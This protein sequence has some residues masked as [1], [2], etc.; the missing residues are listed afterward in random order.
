MDLDIENLAEVDALLAI[1]IVEEQNRRP[2]TALE[3]IAVEAIAEL[4]VTTATRHTAFPGAIAR[5]LMGRLIAL[6]AQKEDN[7][8]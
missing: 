3:Q 4:G 1:L 6:R 5:T 2:F 7:S 8:Q